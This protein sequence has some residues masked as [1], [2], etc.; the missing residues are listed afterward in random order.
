MLPIRRLP[1]LLCVFAFVGSARAV[2]VPAGFRADIAAS[3]P[4]LSYLT[5]LAFDGDGTLYVSEANVLTNSGRVLR[6]EDSDGDGD[7]DVFAEYASGF[8]LVTGITFRG[9]GFPIATRGCAA[10]KGPRGASSA[11]TDLERIRVGELRGKR[12][13]LY[14]SHFTPGPGGSGTLSMVRDGD[15]DGVAEARTDVVAAL[16]SDGDSGNQQPAI[17]NDGRVYFGQGARTN[18]GVPGPGIPPDGPL[19]GTILSVNADGS[20]LRIHAR[21]MRNPFDLLWTPEGELLAT[22]NGPDPS[23]PGPVVGAPD[24]LNSIEPDRHYG[25]PDHFG[26]PPIDS[27]TIGP[28]AQFAPSTSTDGIARVPERSPFCGFEGEIVAAQFGS[29]SD[30]SIGRA[31]A[32]VRLVG[33]RSV[34]VETFAT[35]FGRPL[36]VAF[37]PDGALWVAD[38][39]NA[40]FAPQ[41]ATLY[42]IS[43]EDVDGNG[44]PD[45][46]E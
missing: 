37:A 21:G 23:G 46:C 43:A 36:D 31:L 19:N 30:P 18:A 35:G 8:G 29:F 16:P 9:E 25:W 5:G 6:L 12:L 17:G 20:D 32:L 10:P 27:G 15:G 2:T 41:S 39:S 22:E 45:I 7:I 44:K 40:F 14:V 28:V 33:R 1:V 11:Y 3:G 38:F 24:E 34:L 13:D 4:D 26:F 42:R